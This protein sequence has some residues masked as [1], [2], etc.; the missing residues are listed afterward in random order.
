MT[1]TLF[2]FISFGAAALLTGFILGIAVAIILEG[3]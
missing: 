1:L 2:G 3:L